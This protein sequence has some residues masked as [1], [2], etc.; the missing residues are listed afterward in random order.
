M[1]PTTFREMEMAEGLLPSS[2]VIHTSLTRW[3]ERIRCVP[4][5]AFGIE[6]L[7]RS[8]RQ[9]LYPEYVVPV[10]VKAVEEDP[11]AGELY[12]GELVHAFESIPDGFWREH[13]Q[14]AARLLAV[15]E[16]A[17][18]RLSGDT[19]EDVAAAVVRVEA[20]MAES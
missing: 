3:Y 17:I 4:L 16:G 19:K 7:C 20:A 10:A 2:E 14:L 9:V 5:S 6:D 18:P 13:R 1:I 11:L 8:V 15:M 12:E